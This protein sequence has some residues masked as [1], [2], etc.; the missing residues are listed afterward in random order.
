LQFSRLDIKQAPALHCLN[1][2]CILLLLL[3]LL[4]LL[5]LPPPLLLL[6]LLR[7]FGVLSCAGVR[8]HS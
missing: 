8:H 7:L 6:L 4:L 2:W 3:L 5:P 1:P